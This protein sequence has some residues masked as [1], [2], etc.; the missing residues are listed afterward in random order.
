MT[1]L[2]EILSYCDGG[3]ISAAWITR[4]RTDLPLVVAALQKA[5]TALE[6]YSAGVTCVTKESTMAKFVIDKGEMA[7]ST[8]SEIETMLKCT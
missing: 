8:L 5:V 2:D 3:E 6:V 4:A 1:R 7:R